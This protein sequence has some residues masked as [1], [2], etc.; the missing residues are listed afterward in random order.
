M[1]EPCRQIITHYFVQ[2]TRNYWR[3]QQTVPYEESF[4]DK[5]DSTW[6]LL[7]KFPKSEII[8]GKSNTAIC[9][10]QRIIKRQQKPVSYEAISKRPR[11]YYI[12]IQ[13]VEQIYQHFKTK[14]GTW[15]NTPSERKDLS[16]S[17]RI[18]CPR[19]IFTH[20][21]GALKNCYLLSFSYRIWQCYTTQHDAH[22]DA[23]DA[24]GGQ[25]HTNDEV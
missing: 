7:T 15:S 22:D 16:A 4:W 9:K 25:H 8:V 17:A 3:Q 20:D 11:R 24:V 19:Y 14:V 1:G 10:Q 6:K 13:C 2:K 5:L 23:H 12:Y 21:K 18:G